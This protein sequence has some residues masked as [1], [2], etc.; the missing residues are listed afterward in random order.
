M[1]MYKSR[2]KTTYQK[3][4]QYKNEGESFSDTIDR[5]LTEYETL[6]KHNPTFEVMI[7]EFQKMRQLIYR[8]F[9]EQRVKKIVPASQASERVLELVRLAKGRCTWCKNDLQPK[10][11][12]ITKDNYLHSLVLTCEK[13]YHYDIYVLEYKIKE[14]DLPADIDFLNTLYTRLVEDELIETKIK[15]K[16]ISKIDEKIKSELKKI[17][18]EEPIEER[19]DSDTYFFFVSAILSMMIGMLAFLL[20]LYDFKIPAF[21]M[22]DITMIISILFS[23]IVA[24]LIT[25]NILKQKDREVQESSPTKSRFKELLEFENKVYKKIKNAG[26]ENIKRHFRFEKDKQMFMIDFFAQKN[27][28]NYYFEVKH[29]RTIAPTFILERLGKMATDI[30]ER[31]KKAKLVLITKDKIILNERIKKYLVNWDYIIDETSLNKLKNI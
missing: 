27:K 8:Y 12:V 17:F 19:K 6:R 3:L 28:T 13:P 2:R 23:M 5:I 31:D 16:L 14:S 18:V 20:P 22:K 21:D 15:N 9:A 25:Q 30:K 4:L 1:N 29:F 10:F 7:D 26:F 24:L 11:A